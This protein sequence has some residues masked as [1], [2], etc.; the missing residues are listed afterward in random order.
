MGQMKKL[1]EMTSEQDKP[2]LYFM[3]RTKDLTKACEDVLDRIRTA[4]YL[5]GDFLEEGYTT[6]LFAARSILIDAINLLEGPNGN[7]QGNSGQDRRPHEDGDDSRPG[8]DARVP[9]PQG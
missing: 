6:D 7:A 5:I 3:Q 4:E 1:W 9:A 8:A 2:F